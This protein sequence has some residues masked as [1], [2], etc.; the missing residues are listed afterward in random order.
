M[1]QIL[2]Q[3]KTKKVEL[4]DEDLQEVIGGNTDDKK[5]TCSVYRYRKRY[6]TCPN[7]LKGT[8]K[9]CEYCDLNVD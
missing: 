8:C 5:P 7:S 4:N 3:K 2:C 9:Q 6:N 1:R